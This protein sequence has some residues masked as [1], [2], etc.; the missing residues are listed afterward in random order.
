MARRPVDSNY[1]VRIDVRLLQPRTSLL[2]HKAMS[3]IYT[4]LTIQ[5]KVK[6][7]FET[8]SELKGWKS[9]DAPNKLN[10]IRKPFS[11]DISIIVVGPRTQVLR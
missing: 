10:Q 7:L 8:L 3:E 5:I 2:G 6:L 9:V 1:D 11:S 4:P